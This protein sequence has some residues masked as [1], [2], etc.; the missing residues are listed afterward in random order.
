MRLEIPEETLTFFATRTGTSWWFCKKDA[1][2]DLPTGRA[3]KSVV[4]LLAVCGLETILEPQPCG[5]A[6]PFGGD[7]GERGDKGDLATEIGFAS[8]KVALLSSSIKES[9]ESRF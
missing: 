3:C 2:A 5:E 9:S 4:E 1:E 6:S 8:C 7:I